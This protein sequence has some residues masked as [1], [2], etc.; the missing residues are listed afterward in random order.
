MVVKL[1]LCSALVIGVAVALGGCT[2]DVGIQT[3]ESFAEL[4]EGDYAYRA[5]SAE[6]VVI[7][8]RRE[9]N[10]P[11]GTLAFWSSAIDYELR[12]KG[13]S[14]QSAKSVKSADGVAGKQIRY[15]ASREGRPSVLWTTVFV[16]GGNVIVV[17]AGG[18]AAHF[19]G[20]ESEVEKAINE[21]EVS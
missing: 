6:G 21:V 11:K 12:R 2:R 19:E 13:Y 7:A 4:D 14:A 1:G 8:V 5:T 18:D 16:S 17:E 3:P 15:S 10:D 20:V 9:D